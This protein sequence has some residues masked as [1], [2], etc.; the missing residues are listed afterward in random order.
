MLNGEL[1]A[2]LIVPSTETCLKQDK[3]SFCAINNVKLIINIS[4]FDILRLNNL[5]RECII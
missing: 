4:F 5:L 1:H 3:P 2:N